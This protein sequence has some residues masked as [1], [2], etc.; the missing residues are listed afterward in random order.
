M[1]IDVENIIFYQNYINN[2]LYI[3]PSIIVNKNVN[4][5][6]IPKHWNLSTIHYSD[7]FNIIQK[8]YITLNTFANKPE[9]ASAFKIVAKKLE[10]LT[11]LMKVFLYNKALITN[12]NTEPIN[13][14]QTAPRQVN[15]IFDEKLITL[16][17]TFIF[18]AN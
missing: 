18:Y 13:L 4:Y 6:A 9:L 3:F 16:F 15:S 7:I 2:I 12:P 17:Y 11:Q 14:N 8:Y 1:S 10:V 5:G